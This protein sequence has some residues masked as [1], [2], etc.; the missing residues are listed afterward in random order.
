[1][2][3]LYIKKLYSLN[4][5]KYKNIS[6]EQGLADYHIYCEYFILSLQRRSVVY[7]ITGKYDRLK[8]FR[9][10]LKTEI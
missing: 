8:T 9:Q 5:T 2:P 1:M 4:P 10:W 3:L 7:D 6:L